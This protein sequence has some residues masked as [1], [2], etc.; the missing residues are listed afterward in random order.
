[1]F[2]YKKFDEKMDLLMPGAKFVYLSQFRANAALYIVKYFTSDFVP[3]RQS[4]FRT[5]KGTCTTKKF[6]RY[7]YDINPLKC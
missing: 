2:L 6:F 7:F 4:E 1:M 3:G 5:P